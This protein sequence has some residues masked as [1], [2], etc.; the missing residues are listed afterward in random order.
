MLKTIGDFPD[1]ESVI[2]SAKLIA[3]WLYNH[4]KLHTMMKNAIGGN[5][6]RW[7]ATHFDTNYLF[8][9]SFLR[10]KDCFMQ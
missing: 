1:H 5:I 4:G 10:R 3:K 2:D 6:V 8:F 9:E 7:N